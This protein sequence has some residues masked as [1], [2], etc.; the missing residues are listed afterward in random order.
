MALFNKEV[1]M[2]MTIDD[3]FHLGNS[4]SVMQE[5]LG[6]MALED[7][8]YIESMGTGELIEYEEIAIALKVITCLLDERTDYAWKL[9]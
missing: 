5:V 3:K 4:E 8:D 2:R 9:V 6:K 1:I 7:A